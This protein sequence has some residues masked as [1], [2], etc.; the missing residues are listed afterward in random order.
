MVRSRVGIVFRYVP[1][2]G[3]RLAAV[4]ID[5]RGLGD[6]FKPLHEDTAARGAAFVG[7][8]GG[9]TI[10]FLLAHQWEG[11]FLRENLALGR[12]RL[13]KSCSR[14]MTLALTTTLAFE[15]ETASQRRLSCLLG[16]PVGYRDAWGGWIQLD[17]AIRAREVSS[18]SHLPA[19]AL[20]SFTADDDR[21]HALHAGFEAHLAKPIDAHSLVEA[22]AAL[23]RGVRMS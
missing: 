4:V 19:V 6:V 16:S 14:P 9:T 7:H 20:T 18:Q 15:A 5:V 17:S 1:N 21:Q 8:G 3:A 22:V 10:V 23:A 2:V 11:A 12:S 13:L